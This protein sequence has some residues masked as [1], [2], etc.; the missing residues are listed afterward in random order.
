MYNENEING[1]NTSVRKCRIICSNKINNTV[2]N[3]VP[4]KKR[5]MGDRH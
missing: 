3:A 5:T 2:N 1:L 4:K